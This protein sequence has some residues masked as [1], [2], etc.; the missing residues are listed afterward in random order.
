MRFK[1]LF[2]PALVLS[3]LSMVY[4]DSRSD[5]SVTMAGNPNFSNSDN[6]DHPVH[7]N[8]L[9]N[10]ILGKNN[11]VPITHNI[12]MKT[13]NPFTGYTNVDFLWWRAKGSDWE[14]YSSELINSTSETVRAN[15]EWNPGCR[16]EIGF[17]T[18]LN[19]NVS[20]LW[21]YYH[22]ETFKRYNKSFSD[23]APFSVVPIVKPD[24][25]GKQKIKYNTADIRLSSL[26]SWHNYF[27][28][29]PYMGL[30]G[31][32]IKSKEISTFG[33]KMQ[34]FEI[35]L[36]SL[37]QLESFKGG[38][39]QFGFNLN[40]KVPKSGIE[41]FGDICS[42]LLFGKQRAMVDSDVI[43]MTI[44]F[45]WDLAKTSDTF[46]ELKF[47]LEMEAG[48]RWKYLFDHERKA[49]SLHLSWNQNYWYHLRS[50]SYTEG[51]IAPGKENVM[52]YGFNFG[53]GL[54]Y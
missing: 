37:I 27:V 3:S 19:W 22:N 42:S 35:L 41:F 54:E 2:L 20:A 8:N 32:W 40:F 23:G 43:I 12:E 5:E 51:F 6:L 34:S 33:A 9:R 30:R 17:S 28:V 7:Y 18:P 45:P 29:T 11:Q 4:A 44:V 39:P 49:F 25:S 21:T 14:V 38:G 31:A 47:V 24:N 26:C 48:A 13:V 36:I 50:L 46:T 53:L 16:L 52:Y 10:Y 15:S 1:Y